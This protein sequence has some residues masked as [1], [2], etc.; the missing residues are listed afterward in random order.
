M[1]AAQIRWRSFRRDV[2]RC[3]TP[4]CKAVDIKEGRFWVFGWVFAWVFAWVS[5]WV[6]F[7]LVFAFFVV[8]CYNLFVVSLYGFF[9]EGFFMGSLPLSRD[10][11][12]ARGI[13]VPPFIAPRARVVV[14]K[15]LWFGASRWVIRRSRRS[16]SGCVLWAG[17]PCFGRAARFAAAFGGFCGFPVCVR[18][19][20]SRGGAVW[21]VS[22]PVAP[23]QLRPR[24][25]RRLGG[26]CY[27]FKR[28]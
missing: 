10:S 2:L 1:S 9:L 4:H 21:V 6:F 8:S 14:G 15:A 26:K 3:F 19:L 17:F 20:R 25:V 18:R 16:F 7:P 22:V 12:S 13:S 23:G 5:G 28:V 11:R 24:P 27:F